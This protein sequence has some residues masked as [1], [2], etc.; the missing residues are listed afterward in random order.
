VKTSLGA[1]T[2]AFVTPVWVIGSYDDENRP[3]VMTASWAGICCSKP[4]CV[5]VS[6]RKATFSYGCIAKRRAFTVSVPSEDQVVAADFFGMASG[7][8]MDKLAVAGMTPVASKLVDAPYVAEMPLVLECELRH[9]F[10]VGLHTMFV[11]EIIDVKADSS[12]LG[13]KG[14]P[15]PELV[16]PLVFSPELRVYHGVGAPLGEAFSMG[17]KLMET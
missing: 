7:R 11:G 8:D 14:L 17:K 5:T 12:V 10:E 6:L 4:P 1:R 3:T 9:S 13:E 16:R 15:V 2:M